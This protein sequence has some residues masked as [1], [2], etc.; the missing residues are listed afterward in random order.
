[1]TRFLLVF[2]AVGGAAVYGTPVLAKT[3]TP[4][5]ST[6]PSVSARAAIL[7]DARTGAILYE[8]NA[9]MQLDPAS[10]TKMMTALLVIEHGGLNRVV[11]VSKRADYTPGSSLHIQKDEQYTR[12]DLLKGLL[13]RSGNDA[14]VALAESEAGSVEKFVAEMNVKA[15]QI[16]A[17]NTAYENPNGLT[18]PGHYSSAYD[19]ALIARTA[20][21]YPLFR[22]IVKSSEAQVTE[23]KR[24]RSRTIHSTNQLLYGFPGGDGVKTGTTDAAGKCL[25]G[26]ATR[27]GRQ[28]IAVVLNSGNRYGDASRLL[29]YGFR[30]WSLVEAVPANKRLAEAEVRRGQIQTVGLETRRPV[31]VDV[32][33]GGTYQVYLAAPRVLSAP[34]D[35]KKAAGFASVEVAG[36]PPARQALYPRRTIKAAS[37]PRRLWRH[38]FGRRHPR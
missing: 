29:N 31:W 23:L 37:A 9:F 26:S 10:T 28:L 36:Q 19:L 2:G 1:M 6:P 14:S 8:K 18:K 13:L 15:Q 22:E 17:F 11:T 3:S 38:L 35:R 24:H 7:V 12:L 20:L 27:D 16:G 25:V 33:V 30:E 34:V 5:P 4:D 21:R 32:P